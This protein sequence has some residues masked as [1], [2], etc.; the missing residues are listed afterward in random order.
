MRLVEASV[1]LPIQQ[2]LIPKSLGLLRRRPR[3]ARLH[4][5]PLV[6]A[7]PSTLPIGTG[8]LCAIRSILGAVRAR[9]STALPML[10]ADIC[11]L[12]AWDLIRPAVPILVPSLSLDPSRLPKP[13]A[14]AR[15]NDRSWSASRLLRSRMRRRLFSMTLLCAQVPNPS[16][17][18]ARRLRQFAHLVVR[19]LI[20]I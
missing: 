3:G 17:R 11:A 2:H 7:V 4:T 19:Q 12:S 20:P 18:D 8:I 9:A 15:S 16:R 6:M 1:R 14:R 13:R 10:A 5:S